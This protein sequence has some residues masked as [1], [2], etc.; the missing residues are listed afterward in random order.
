VNIFPADFSS[1]LCL[2]GCFIANE[3][4]DDIGRVFRELAD[5]LELDD[6]VCVLVKRV[7]CMKQGQE[8][9]PRPRETPVITQEDIVMVYKI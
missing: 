9:T 2:D 5:E 8:R 1:N 4:E 7:F 6:E 3:A